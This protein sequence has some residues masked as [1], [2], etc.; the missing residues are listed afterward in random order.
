MNSHLFHLL[1]QS[2]ILSVFFAVLLHEEKRRRVRFGAI[3][4]ASLTGGTILLATLMLP[5]PG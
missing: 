4:F 3:L 5:F 2:L 1:L